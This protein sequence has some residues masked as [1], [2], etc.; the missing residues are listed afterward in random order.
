MSDTVSLDPGTPVRKRRKMGVVLHTTLT[1]VT[2]AVADGTEVWPVA[3]VTEA[4][5]TDTAVTYAVRELERAREQEQSAATALEAYRAKFTQSKLHIQEVAHRQGTS[6]SIGPGLDRLLHNNGLR[7]R[8]QRFTRHV[9]AR[10]RFVYTGME[11][12]L[13]GRFPLAVDMYATHARFVPE[14]VMERVVVVDFPAEALS[15]DSQDECTCGTDTDLP[16]REVV[17][18]AIERTFNSPYWTGEVLAFTLLFVTG[19]E[20]CDHYAQRAAQG[21]RI[22]DVFPDTPPLVEELPALMVGDEVE[23]TESHW[24]M[25]QGWRFTVVRI[26]PDGDLYGTSPERDQAIPE[27]H[28]QRAYCRRVNLRVGDEVEVTVTHMGLRRG[29]RIRVTTPPYQSRTGEYLGGVLVGVEDDPYHYQVRPSKVALVTT[30]P[31]LPPISD[32]TPF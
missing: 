32:D 13:G 20:H 31:S 16:D 10:V 2:V 4:S 19:I 8:P 22:R 12:S 9:A 27:W 11:S 14:V 30:V 29:T 15:F 18:R 3:E 5:A 25:E 17:R 6:H 21:T 26:A 23:I 1:D 24:S 28:I 7:P